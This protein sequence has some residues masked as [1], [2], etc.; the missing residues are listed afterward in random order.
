MMELYISTIPP[1]NTHRDTDSPLHMPARHREDA[2]DMLGLRHSR[3][4]ESSVRIDP[5]VSFPASVSL[6]CDYASSSKQFFKEEIPFELEQVISADVF[7]TRM[8][9][10]NKRLSSYWTLRD[11]SSTVRSFVFCSFTG[12][13]IALVLCLSQVSSFVL[14]G[15]VLAGLVAVVGVM[16]LTYRKKSFVRFVENELKRF[17]AE[18][19]GIPLVWKSI[20]QDTLQLYSWDVR[21]AEMWKI[22]VQIGMSDMC[23]GGRMDLDYLPP[24]VPP[25]DSNARFLVCGQ[26]APDA[27]AV[28]SATDPP[29]YKNGAALRTDNAAQSPIPGIP[30]STAGNLI[31]RPARRYTVLAT[32]PVRYSEKSCKWFDDQMPTTLQPIIPSV[33]FVTR[34]QEINSKLSRF[35]SLRDYTPLYRVVGFSIYGTFSITLAACVS[36][37]SSAML[38]ALILC[39]LIMIIISLWFSY[40][41]PKSVRIVEAELRRFTRE[42]EPFG[43]VWE[44]I[45]KDDRP[46]YACGF[47]RRFAEVPWKIRVKRD[48]ELQISTSNDLPA[49]TAPSSPLLENDGVDGDVLSCRSGLP[50]YSL[51][52]RHTTTTEGGTVN[53]RASV[54]SFPMS[55][56]GMASPMASPGIQR[57]S[58]IISIAAMPLFL[59][60]HR[61]PGFKPE[62]KST[63]GPSR[64]SDAAISRHKSDPTN[65][66]H[67]STLRSYSTVRSGSIEARGVRI[68]LYKVVTSDVPVQEQVAESS[69]TMHTLGNVGS[70]EPV[71]D[72]ENIGL[73]EDERKMD[74]Q[75]SIH[76]LALDEK[77]EQSTL[78]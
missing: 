9:V 36:L 13:T 34:I 58:Q 54:V 22:R 59:S 49:Y 75:L 26:G 40:S 18:D 19:H 41:T 6:H 30:A 71:K 78:L 52:S 10:I 16:T 46:P 50:T 53:H 63:A 55:L 14:W 29:S 15:A 28:G 73:E 8:Q 66:H 38:W 5:L 33:T 74:T 37:F 12:Y 23:G 44:S 1:H 65:L 77:T 47:S 69:I 2:I 45:R 51:L 62:R 72:V 24:Y 48:A 42:D 61:D 3:L 57:T 4:A 60:D 31:I 35:K 27:A 11:Y 32:L 7:T 68:G 56:H 20:R 25:D 76:E 43:L 17:N 39:G 21:P 70:S 64:I 67:L